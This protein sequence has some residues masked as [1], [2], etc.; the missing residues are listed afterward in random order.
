MAPKDP[1]AHI[2]GPAKRESSLR[3]AKP[4]ANPR[5]YQAVQTSPRPPRLVIQ[6]SRGASHAPSYA[7]LVNVIFDRRFGGSFVLIYNF[8]AIT[9]TGRNLAAVVHAI[10]RHRAGIITEFES[11]AHDAPSA[12]APVI[13]GIEVQAGSMMQEQIAGVARNERS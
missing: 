1:F 13:T 8:M 12:D 6:C 3:L 9:V 5:E 2:I 11:A 7:L 4:D 10:T